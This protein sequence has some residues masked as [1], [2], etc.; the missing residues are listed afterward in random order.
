MEDNKYKKY[1]KF[2]DK[3]ID[4][5][6]KNDFYIEAFLLIFIVLDEELKYIINNI[7]KIDFND[8]T[9]GKLIEYLEK[10]N[11]DN[12]IIFKLKI[13]NEKRNFIIHNFFKNNTEINELE[14]KKLISE[15]Y[16]VLIKI[17]DKEI[18]NSNN[19]TN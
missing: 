5:L 16:K 1:L 6:Q 18:K 15:V 7:Y 2:L 14:F 9:F 4:N 11:F 12:N 17:L 13:F 3:R 19:P 8:K 10:N